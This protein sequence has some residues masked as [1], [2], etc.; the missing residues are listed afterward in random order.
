AR[1]NKGF[2]TGFSSAMG[3][4]PFGLGNAFTFGQMAGGW[5][6]SSP[7]APGKNIPPGEGL[8]PTPIAPPPAPMKEFNMK[9]WAFDFKTIL[10]YWEEYV[11]VQAFATDGASRQYLQFLNLQKAL[12]ELGDP[13]RDVERLLPGLTPEQQ[14]LA[15]WL[16]WREAADRAIADVELKA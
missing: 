4:M 16:A 1:D 15:R 14:T 3:A 9:D 7:L 12:K 8:I 5:L 13:I 11:Q 10:T 6:K 2:L